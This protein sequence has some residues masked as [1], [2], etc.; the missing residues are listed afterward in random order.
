MS[1]LSFFRWESDACREEKTPLEATGT[2]DGR[3]GV[4]RTKSL[5]PSPPI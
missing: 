2:K 1:G 5:T 3:R 4:L